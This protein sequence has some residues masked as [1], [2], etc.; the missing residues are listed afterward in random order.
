MR[1]FVWILVLITPVARGEAPATRP[2][3]Q[4]AAEFSADSPA[5]VWFA[6][7]ASLDET[8]RDDARTQLMGLTR[9]DLPR[10]RELVVKNRPLVAEQA[11]ALHEIVVHVYL[12]GEPYSA[13]NSNGF[14]GL[15]WPQEIYDDSSRLG[16]AVENRLP[17]FPSFQLLRDGD[18]IHGVYV[19]PDAPL[20]Q[21]PNLLT[22][23]RGALTHVVGEA[24]ANSTVVLEVLRQGQM[25][26]VAM[27][28]AAKPIL[29][30]MVPAEVEAFFSQ[31]SQKGE[32]YWQEEFLPLIRPGMS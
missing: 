21:L 18:L 17:G 11:A 15:L 25:I 3:T 1:W 10:L 14:L 16:V 12:T 27:R 29:P 32:K 26:K 8:K 28:L 23:N 30:E 6:Q 2:S 24:G 22:P 7:L 19:N 9:D 5:R 4:P 13:N 20:Q 31:R